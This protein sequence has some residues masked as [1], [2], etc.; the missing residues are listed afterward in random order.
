VKNHASNGRMASVWAMLPVGIRRY[1]E[2][3]MW[4]VVLVAYIVD[5]IG[6]GVC[7]EFGGVVWASL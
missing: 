3:V 1:G 5:G 4:Y 2:V 7:V 6:S